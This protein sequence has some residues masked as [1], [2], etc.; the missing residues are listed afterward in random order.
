MSDLT[1]FQI[2]GLKTRLVQRGRELKDEIRE[3][4]N[5]VQ[6]SVTNG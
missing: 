1:D 4:L 2:D 5:A 6:T 3:I